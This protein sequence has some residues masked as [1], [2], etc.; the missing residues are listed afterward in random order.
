[1]RQEIPQND[2]RPFGFALAAGLF[3]ATIAYGVFAALSSG[4][5]WLALAAF[6]IV[7]MWVLGQ[8]IRAHDERGWRIVETWKE[9]N[10]PRPFPFGVVIPAPLWMIVP[11]LTEHGER[12]RVG[13]LHVPQYKVIV[14]RHAYRPA[15]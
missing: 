5:E 12:R 9:A 3:A 13:G 7:G 15:R 8:R 4:G 11:P 14:H 1:M 2:A 6:G 10:E